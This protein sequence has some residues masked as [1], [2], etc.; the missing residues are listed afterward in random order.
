MSVHDW[1]LVEDGI[2]HDFHVVWTVA[3][4][5]TLNASLL[6]KGYYAL[7]EQHA[8]ASI[9]DI[10]TL[11][12]SPAVP[13]PLPP[14]ADSGGVAV[15]QAPPKARIQQTI[16]PREESLRARQRS[17]AI[18]HVSDHRLV[19][20]LEIVSPGNKDRGLSVDTF[21]NKA[22]GALSA[23]VHLLIVDLFAPGRH[24]PCGVHGA[25]LQALSQ[26]NEC[27][28]R[29]P[30]DEPPT[31]AAYASG[32]EVKSYVE[33][34]AIGGVIPEMPLFLQTERYVNVPFA[35]TYEA[36]YR[37]VPEFYREILEGKPSSAQA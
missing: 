27:H 3:I 22:A 2:F 9:A 24:D 20:L 5:N 29:G 11:H 13:A 1:T 6:P 35:Q 36:T 18:R 12:G 23:G 14:L 33:H 17:I 16:K 21:A 19:A 26:S 10:L 32:D 8:G 4:R 31:V 37:G 7:A 15:A 28:Y 34:F 25:I 30:P